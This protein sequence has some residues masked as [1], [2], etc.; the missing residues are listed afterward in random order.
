MNAGWC[1]QDD[2]FESSDTQ[3]F[4][5]QHATEEEYREFI[6]N[7]SAAGDRAMQRY[8]AGR[9]QFVKGFPQMADW[10]QASLLRRVGR[11]YWLEDGT[12]PSTSY[13]RTVD[14]VCYFARP[15]LYFLALRGYL[16]FDLQWLLAARHLRGTLYL[17]EAGIEAQ[18]EPLI[19]EGQTLG[20]AE[21]TLRASLWWLFNRFFLHHGG[22]FD[23][24][25][26]TE[27]DLAKFRN[28]VQEFGQRS[29]V[30]LFYGTRDDYAR[31]AKLARANLH[32]LGVILYHR[33]QIDSLPQP[34][35]TPDPSRKPTSKPRMEATA[36]R[37]VSRRRPSI[38]D[39][40]ARQTDH[41]LRKFIDWVSEEYPGM[42][43]FAEVDRDMVLDYASAT[44]RMNGRRT[45][46]PL[47]VAT[48]SKLLET[49]ATFF[50]LTAEWGWEDVPGRRLL[51]PG[52][53]PK[54]VRGVPRYIPE[55]ELAPLMEAVRELACPYQRTAILVARWSGARRDEIRRL[56]MDCLDAYP[57]GTPR[58]RIPAG[59]THTERVVPLNEEA[60]QAVR[61]LKTSVHRG[62]GIVDRVT[63][64]PTHY[65]FTSRG[66]LLSSWYL[67]DQGLK[68][69]REAAGVPAEW[70]GPGST[71]HRFRHTLGMQLA[72][73]GAKLYTVMNVLGHTSPHM[74]LV[75]AR[76][77]DDAVKQDY[78]KV[79]GPGA[80]IAGPLAHTI[81]AGE[82]PEADVEWI[83]TNFFK[84]E[85]EL[86]HCLRLPQEGPCECDLYLS[87]AK[88]VT[89]RDYTT[90]LRVRRA[91]ELE[92]VE[93]AK[94]RGWEREIERHRR[95]AQR[96]E[97]LL[98]DL[99]EP[100]EEE[101]TG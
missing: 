92:L 19:E 80:E 12:P 75:Y 41:Y 35:G 49:L 77:S 85:L 27:G 66:K 52:D 37:Y 65:L 43:S 86:G 54:Q 44:S 9:R 97:Q 23:A 98:H 2:N 17:K 24:D 46:R 91:L 39:S 22:K 1:P 8:L 55:A 4:V 26:I 5:P 59:K 7:Y 14:Y 63:K 71:A 99:G 73:R 18:M 89:T 70:N 79:L 72:E 51:G 87:C 25:S 38:S 47:A 15:Y 82:L 57:D 45:G 95:T 48:R 58:L 34:R 31:T 78:E 40:Y 90:R 101:A 69:A 10:F 42:E 93:D 29:D 13:E 100:I 62:R 60:A 32:V 94:T 30:E 11:T 81:K 74:S 21:K 88:F 96:I 6:L 67:F 3:Q 28:A 84:T 53:L 56:E 36:K 68:K 83:K 76:V 16:Q 61:E 64:L 50:S 20:Y 33:G